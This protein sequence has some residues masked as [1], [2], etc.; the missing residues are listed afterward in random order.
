MSLPEGARL[1]VPPE[2]PPPY[3]AKT[4]W[5]PYYPSILLIFNFYLKEFTVKYTRTDLTCAFLPKLNRAGTEKRCRSTWDLSPEHRFPTSHC[6][7]GPPIASVL[8]KGTE[9]IKIQ[10][11]PP[12]PPM[13]LISRAP[14]T[15][16]LKCFHLSV[17]DT[18]LWRKY[19]RMKNEIQLQ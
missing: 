14:P 8:Y 13:V 4:L 15:P 6:A 7:P 2:L 10:T 17:L 9:S 18:A 12:P 11:P 1:T 19:S 5:F 16:V 3:E